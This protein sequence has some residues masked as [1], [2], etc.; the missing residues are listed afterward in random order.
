[1]EGRK[2]LWDAFVLF[3]IL[4]Y[5]APRHE[6]LKLFVS[7]QPEHF[8]AT[9]GCIA[10]FEALIDLVKKIFEFEAASGRKYCR[11]FLCH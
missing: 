11:Q 7:P 10:R 9:A 4:F 5:H 3:D 8:F 1:M 2:L 6:I